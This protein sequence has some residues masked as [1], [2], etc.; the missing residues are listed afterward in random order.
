MDAICY[1]LF[2]LIETDQ[3]QHSL[4]INFIKLGVHFTILEKL[5]QL[6]SM[7]FLRF[8]SFFPLA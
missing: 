8:I 6:I 3:N 4:H 1:T 7:D 2:L 5:K